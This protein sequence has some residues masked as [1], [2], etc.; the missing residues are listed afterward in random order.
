[1]KMQRVWSTS[2]TWRPTCSGQNP[3]SRATAKGHCCRPVTGTQRMR[4]PTLCHSNHHRQR[5]VLSVITK[6]WRQPNCGTDT[7]GAPQRQR[8]KLVVCRS[9]RSAWRASGGAPGGTSREKHQGSSAPCS[10]HRKVGEGRECRHTICF[11][12][13]LCK[14]GLFRGDVVSV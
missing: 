11:H 6:G 1:M 7:K 2:L 3:G 9:R 5:D 12:Q 14:E 4:A 10:L 13:K 8:S